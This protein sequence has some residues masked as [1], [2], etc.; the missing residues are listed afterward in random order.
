MTAPG[1]SDM[2]PKVLV[3]DDERL[4][5]DTLATIL[6]GD[7]F[8]AATTYSGTE[9]VRAALDWQPDIF[10]SDVV[11][12]G[13]NGIEAAI[14]ICAMI[15]NCRVLLLSGQ[16]ATLDML[17]DANGRGHEFELLLKP[18]HPTELLSRLHALGSP[19][20]WD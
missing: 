17:L 1:S 11:M 10:L 3:A 7:G 6:R 12:P 9:A 4:I 18:I 2:R 14:Q 8:D 13:I 19:P 5:A 20:R 16:A 15:P